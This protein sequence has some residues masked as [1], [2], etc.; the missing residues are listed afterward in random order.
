[1]SQPFGCILVDPAGDGLVES[2]HD[3]LDPSCEKLH[4]PFLMKDMTKPWPES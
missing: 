3:F 2:V 4:D 1:M